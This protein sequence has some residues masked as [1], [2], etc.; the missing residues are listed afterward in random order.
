MI[1]YYIVK[2]EGNIEHF[3]VIDK[4]LLYN[5]LLSFYEIHITITKTVILLLLKHTN[6]DQR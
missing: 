3:L 5:Y 2:E 1:N 4:M 6:G